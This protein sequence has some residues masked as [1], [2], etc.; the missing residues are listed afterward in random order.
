MSVD[1]RDRIICTAFSPISSDKDIRSSMAFSCEQNLRSCIIDSSGAK[2][3]SSELHNYKKLSL[4]INMPF[5]GQDTDSVLS[6]MKNSDLLDFL[7]VYVSFDKFLVCYSNIGQ[8]RDFVKEINEICPVP[9][10]FGVEYSWIK[11]RE[12]I[13]KICSVLE[14]YEKHNLCLTTY[15][16]K[17]DKLNEILSIGK[18]LGSNGSC[19]FSYLGAIPNKKDGIVE[20]LSSGFSFCGLPKQFLGVVI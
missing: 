15:C 6:M 7:D 9:I 5:N 17:P 8:I 13:D 18:Y 10:N 12:I 20:I 14:P 2:Q 3:L 16:N 4:A 1:I 19:K 11:N